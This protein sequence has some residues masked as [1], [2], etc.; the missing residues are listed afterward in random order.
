M[1]TLTPTVPVDPELGKNRTKIRVRASYMLTNSHLEPISNL[2]Y[3]FEAIFEVDP[4]DAQFYVDVEFQLRNRIHQDVLRQIGQDGLM[5]WVEL[6]QMSW[7]PTQPDKDQVWDI[8]PMM[9][10][11]QLA[12]LYQTAYMLQFTGEE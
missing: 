5:P 9:D 12:M 10:P 11:R 8:I 7:M 3:R 4:D 2:D 1:N 6:I